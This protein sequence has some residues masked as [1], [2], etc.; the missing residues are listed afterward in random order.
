MGKDQQRKSYGG[1]RPFGCRLRTRS[2]EEESETGGRE[3][4]R[5]GDLREGKR[6]KGSEKGGGSRGG[7]CDAWKKKGKLT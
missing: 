3:E 6:K 2:E 7:A 5:L 1:G 4:I